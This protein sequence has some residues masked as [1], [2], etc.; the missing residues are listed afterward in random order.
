MN[1][2]CDSL[3]LTDDAGSMIT[4]GCV[5]LSW[6]GRNMPYVVALEDNCGHMSCEYNF[7]IHAECEASCTP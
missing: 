4:R 5:T 3:S 2:W 1:E 7:V 6:L